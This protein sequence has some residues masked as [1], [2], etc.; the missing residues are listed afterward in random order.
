MS[1]RRPSG[2]LVGNALAEHLRNIPLLARVPVTRA[3]AS[4]SPLLALDSSRRFLG[5]H[6]VWFL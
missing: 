5:R 1:T 3:R 6:L 4:R 2:L